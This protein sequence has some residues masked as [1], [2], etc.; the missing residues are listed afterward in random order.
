MIDWLKEFA[1][2]VV[3]TAA[4]YERECPVKQFRVVVPHCFLN[5]KGPMF[6]SLIVLDSWGQNMG[7]LLRV[8]LVIS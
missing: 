7:P 1:M 3:L 8:E 2:V 4:S 5:E 6:C